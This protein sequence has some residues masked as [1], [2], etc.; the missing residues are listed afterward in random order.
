MNENKK[1]YYKLKSMLVKDDFL[2]S[3]KQ[4][5]D[6]DNNINLLATQ[7]EAWFDNIYKIILR[8]LKQDHINYLY[9]IEEIIRDHTEEYNDILASNIHDYYISTSET[10]EA[11]INNKVANKTLDNSLLYHVAGKDRQGNLDPWINNV[12]EDN[13]ILEQI[14]KQLRYN[15]NIQTTLNKY[16]RKQ[17]HQINLR[18]TFQPTTFSITELLEHEI[19]EAITEYMSSNIFTASE[20]TLTRVTQ[21]IYDIIRKEYG[22]DGQGIPQ[23]TTEIQKQFTELKRFEA[24]RIART[25]TLKAQGHA[26][27]K[28]LVNNPD[29]EYIQWKSTDDEKT[30]ESHVELNGEITYADGNGVFSN[31]LQYPGDANGDIEEW[32][33]CRCD[34]VAF[35]PELGFVPPPGAS[36]WYEDEMLFD[37]SIEIPEVHVEMDEYLASWW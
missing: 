20:S 25:E 32:I 19:D 9:Q 3:K 10:K 15:N 34:P 36:N 31:G 12:D 35:I 37:T 23:V 4:S 28:R 14:K 22:E 18:G 30:R 1:I 27:W 16:L 21:E 17:G 5:S 2:L 29:C 8:R 33:N 7:L 11:Q 13:E 6:T 24:E 26:A